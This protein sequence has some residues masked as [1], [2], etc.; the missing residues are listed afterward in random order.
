MKKKEY[1]LKY[2]LYSEKSILVEWPTRIDEDILTDITNYKAQIKK[3]VSQKIEEIISGYNSLLILYKK[4]IN[5]FETKVRM[6]QEMNQNCNEVNTLQ[7]KFWEIP[8]CYSPNLAPD[9]EHF[10]KE[11]SLSI[12]EIIQLHTNAEYKVFFIGFLPGFLYL[13]GLHAKLEHPRKHTPSLQV[14]KGAV[15]IG[16]SQTGIYP[17]DSPGGWY[18]I[19]SCP[20]PMF[21]VSQEPPS[22]FAIGDKISFISISEE[23]YRRL[24]KKSG[25]SSYQLKPKNS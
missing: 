20:I 21:D 9:L 15:A 8:V 6:L 23:E 12:K 7:N 18:I 22:C 10:A 3:K 11:K 24:K 14:K 16:G 5:D 25:A 4:Q 13:G 2:K 19:G 17:S 1:I